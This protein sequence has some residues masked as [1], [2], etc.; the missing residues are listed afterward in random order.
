MLNLRALVLSCA[1]YSARPTDTVPL[2]T[3]AQHCSAQRQS[4]SE[5][6]IF[7][8]FFVLLCFLSLTARIRHYDTRMQLCVTHVVV[9]YLAIA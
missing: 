4:T 9:S 5:K 7:V 8:I 3:G 1:W 2:C 6:F